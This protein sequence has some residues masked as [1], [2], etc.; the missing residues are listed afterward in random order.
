MKKDRFTRR[1]RRHGMF[2]LQSGSQFITFAKD[3][4]NF[5][6]QPD[7]R[8]ANAFDFEK[9]SILYQTINQVVTDI[10]LLTKIN[11]KLSAV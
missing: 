2:V 11:G 5:G 1:Q 8:R 6:L 3:G 7:L 4:N 9:A 10:K